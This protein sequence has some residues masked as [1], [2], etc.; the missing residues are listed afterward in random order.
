[1]LFL[2]D[3]GSH[4]NFVLRFPVLWRWHGG[5]LWR[6]GVEGPRYPFVAQAVE[7]ERV[8][9]VSTQQKLVLGAGAVRNGR[10]SSLAHAFNKSAYAQH[11]FI[12]I[13]GGRKA[14]KY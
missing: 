5:R 12:F 11:L 2:S 10:R 3:F 1:M 13:Q 9:D 6:D 7:V 4:L 8:P 14:I